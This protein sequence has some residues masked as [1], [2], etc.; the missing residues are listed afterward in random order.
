MRI[1]VARTIALLSASTTLLA[2]AACSPPEKESAAS[3]S[4]AAKAVSAADLGGLDKLVA[5]AKKEGAAQRHRAAA[6]LGQ[7][8]RDHQ[9]VHREVRH[10]G[11]LRAA[12]R[13]RARTRSTRRTSS[14]ARTT[15]RTCSTSAAPWRRPTS[16]CSRRTRWRPGTTCRPRSR[17]PNGTWVNDYGGYM[18]IGYDSSKVPAPTSVADLLKPEFKGK[19]ALNGDPT[20]AGAAFSGVVMAALGNGGSADDISQGRRL[21][22]PAEEGRQLP[23]GRPDPGHHRV[24]PDAGRHR[25]GLPERRPGREAPGQ[26]RLEDGRAGERR[27]R[28]VLRAGDQQGRPAPRRRP[29]VAGVPLL[30]RGP[31]PVAQGWRASGAGRRHGQG[32]HDR[33]GRVRQR[34]RPTSGD[35]GV[36]DRRADHEGQGRPGD[37]LGE[38]RG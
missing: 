28:L 37:Q 17:T 8:R 26:G 38:G 25:L 14:R 18:S 13:G 19:V 1:S 32:R 20:Q 6:G 5:A 3:N 9:G 36:P 2:I 15:R 4:D 22:R 33:Q 29:A 12:G 30:R 27:G 23:A 21:L 34:C 31:E 7:L 24:R 35:A 16:R 10:Q 11:Q